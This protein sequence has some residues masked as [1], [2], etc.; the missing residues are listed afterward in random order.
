[1]LGEC[2]CCAV[3]KEQVKHL[4][5]LLDQTLGLIAPKTSE[6]AEQ[7]EKVPDVEVVKFG[8]P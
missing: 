7:P 6:P 4:Q 5:G 1:M 2:K 3:Y 8:E